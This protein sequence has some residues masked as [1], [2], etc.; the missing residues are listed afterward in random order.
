MM[1]KKHVDRG[2]RS[3]ALIMSK[4]HFER[5]HRCT[6][7]NIGKNRHALI[8]SASNINSCCF[9]SL[10]SVAPSPFANGGLGRYKVE[11]DDG[12]AGGGGERF[13]TFI[14]YRLYDDPWISEVR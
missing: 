1:G 13:P 9:E 3:T 12:L 6:L 11:K 2:H 10:F 8:Q 4:R 5:G 14:S 7:L